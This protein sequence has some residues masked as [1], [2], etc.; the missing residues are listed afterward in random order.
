MQTYLEGAE[1]GTLK[2]RVELAL[3]ADPERFDPARFASLAREVRQSAVLDI[4]GDPCVTAGT[5]KF[6][7]DGVVEAGTAA[8]L[9][10][11]ADNPHTCGLPVWD[12]AGLA[13]GVAEAEVAG[14]DVHIHAI[15]DAGIRN[16]L[17]AIAASP[18]RRDPLRRPTIAHVQV[19]HPDDRA[20][21]A[22]LGVTANFE[23]LWACWDACQREL[24][25]PR[26]GPERTAW[27]YPI[28]SLM[29]DGVEVSFGT[30]W[31]VSDVD[32]LRCA[33]VAVSRRVD[34][35]RPLVAAE[36]ITA[37]A[38]LRAASRGVARQLGQADW[39]HVSVGARADL[40]VLSADPRN[41]PPDD[42]TGIEV[43]GRFQA[44]IPD[45]P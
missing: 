14:F 11:Y 45:R 41:V 9:E 4:A 18:G 38:A 25:A 19:V 27:Q 43:L 24:T 21:F 33:A 29:A 10:P 35:G 15:G 20:R 37:A 31:P 36:R 1:A 8:L 6:F 39:G 22:S 34:G 13:L 42:W 32:P 16:A 26:L 3:R 40:V 5:V 44:G 12:A 23:P 17:D 30:D 28:G 7:S 2:V